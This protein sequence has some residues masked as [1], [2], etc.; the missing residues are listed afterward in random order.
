MALIEIKNLSIYTKNQTQKLVDDISFALK[1]GSITGLVG[2]SG[3]GK[4][5]TA[6]S[7]MQLLPESL[8]ATGEINFDESNGD[9]FQL[10]KASQKAL[11][12]YRGKKAAMIFQ[13]PMSSLNPSQKT[14]VQVME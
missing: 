10:D 5:L 3:S 2:E 4:S 9:F 13:D 11:M 6:L 7:V 14:G 12:A 8:E 1:K